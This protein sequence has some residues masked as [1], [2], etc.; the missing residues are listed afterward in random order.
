[1]A[2]VGERGRHTCC[3]GAPGRWRRERQLGLEKGGGKGSTAGGPA[4]HAR[5][6]MGWA[7]GHWAKRPSRSVGQLGRLGQKLKEK[8]FRNKIGSLN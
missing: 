8:S 3:D 7:E 2:S 4:R 6:S 1:M 5:R